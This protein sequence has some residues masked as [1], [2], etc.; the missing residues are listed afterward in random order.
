MASEIVLF[1]GVFIMILAAIGGGIYLHQNYVVLSKD[2]METQNKIMSDYTKSDIKIIT[3]TLNA[4]STDVLVYNNGSVLLDTSYVNMYI[5]NIMVSRENLTFD[6]LE[7]A[8]DNS[9]P[10]RYNLT[11]TYDK[12]ITSGD[13]VLIVCET[14][15]KDNLTII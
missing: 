5:N 1:S 9:W 4:Q 6:V 14:G 10:S 12:R 2:I 11:I 13:N 3:I 8:N 7:T 15:K